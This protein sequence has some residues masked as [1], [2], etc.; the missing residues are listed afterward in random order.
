MPWILCGPGRPPDSTGEAAGST[1]IT[2]RFY[3][4]PLGR[5]IEAWSGKPFAFVRPTTLVVHNPG[6]PRGSTRVVQEAGPA[7][8]TIDYGRRVYRRGR[9]ARNERWRVR[10]Q[11]ENR[12]VEVGTR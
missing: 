1:A 9:L 7:G 4:Q 12:I 6:L 11:P 5:R 8:F 10:Y 2:V 3:S